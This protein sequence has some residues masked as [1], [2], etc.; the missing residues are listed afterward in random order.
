MIAVLT[1]AQKVWL[2]LAGPALVGILVFLLWLYFT[3]RR[4]NVGPYRLSL[5]GQKEWKQL[6][7]RR[8]ADRHFS[9]P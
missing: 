9:N 1:L 4:R 5:R 8:H 2:V 3:H 6:E 7:R